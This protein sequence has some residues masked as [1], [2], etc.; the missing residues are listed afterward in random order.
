ME[1]AK[2]WPGQTSEAHPEVFT[3]IPPQPKELKP[4]QFT[5]E[6]V[7]QYFEKVRDEYRWMSSRFLLLHALKYG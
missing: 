4:G 6:Q 7:K 3:T 2:K 5:P 1:E